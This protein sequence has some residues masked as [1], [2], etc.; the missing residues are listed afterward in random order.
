MAPAIYEAV[1]MAFGLVASAFALLLLVPGL[2][3]GLASALTA[4][5]RGPAVALARAT[6]STARHRVFG[7][8]S[9]LMLV[10]TAIFLILSVLESLKHETRDFGR[11]ALAGR[12][13]VQLGAGAA[14]RLPELRDV[15]PELTALTPLSAEVAGAFVV[16]GIDG[17]LLEYGPFADDARLRAA[18][19][20]RPTI[21]LSTRCAD[22]Q[23]KGVGD[24]VRLA[25]SADGIVDF[26]V[27]AVSDAHGFAPDNRVYGVVSSDIMRSAWCESGEGLPGWFSARVPDLTAARAE[28]LTA[29]MAG[30]VGE[31]QIFRSQRGED[32]TSAYVA[33]LEA[34]FAIFHAIL[35]LT[36]LLAAVGILNAMVIAVM[37][38]R[39]EI[40][41]LR[42]VGMTGGQ[43]GAMLLCESGVL[44]VLGG[45]T[46]LILGVPLAATVCGALT[47]VSHL[48]L[49]FALEP[50]AL[51]VVMGGAV[52][53]SVLAV[54]LPALRA[55]SLSLSRVVRYE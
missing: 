35:A 14:A 41:L 48:D 29:L 7:T 4:P 5:F 9:G 25:T 17:G 2:L 16:R 24:S 45:A 8:V 47:E 30:V 51:V 32:I 55:N 50:R 39:R 22:D 38:R 11:R 52:A 42:A 13:F 31:D 15:A 40:G 46:G 26:E 12:Y 49:T 6:L 19:V 53:V 37:E 20:G 3:R 21:I 43:V 27:L 36:V 33:D 34:N 18:F 54:A 1:L 23:G 44:G 28:Q 10:F